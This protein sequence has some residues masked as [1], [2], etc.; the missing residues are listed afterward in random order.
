MAV[1]I[2]LLSTVTSALSIASSMV[3]DVTGSDF[4]PSMCSSLAGFF[5]VSAFFAGFLGAAAFS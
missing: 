4:L 1:L 2:L 3:L 5:F